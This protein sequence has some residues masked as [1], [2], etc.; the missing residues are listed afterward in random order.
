MMTNAR[1]ARMRTDAV[2]AR[3]KP[4]DNVHLMARQVHQLPSPQFRQILLQKQTNV[5]R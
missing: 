5:G 3:M 2:V 1:T 4:S